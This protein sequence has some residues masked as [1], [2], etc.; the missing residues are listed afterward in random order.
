[1]DMGDDTGAMLLNFAELRIAR[2]ACQ[3]QFEI[4]ARRLESS[5]SGG[6]ARI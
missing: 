4:S 3:N 2:C 6:Q 1:M 5:R